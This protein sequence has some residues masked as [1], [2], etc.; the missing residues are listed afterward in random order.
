MTKFKSL[1]S[2]EIAPKDSCVILSWVEI[3]TDCIK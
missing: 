2:K 1:I 3:D